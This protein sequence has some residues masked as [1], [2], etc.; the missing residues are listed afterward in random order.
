MPLIGVALSVIIFFT[1]LSLMP[2]NVVYKTHF[3]AACDTLEYVLIDNVFMNLAG[4]TAGPAAPLEVGV[5]IKSFAGGEGI[6][7]TIS[8]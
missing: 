6:K 1:C 7:S 3:E 2:R 8:N 5:I 4:S